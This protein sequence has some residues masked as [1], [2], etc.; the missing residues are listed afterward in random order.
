VDINNVFWITVQVDG[1][2]N[3]GEVNLPGIEQFVVV[4]QA[5]STNIQLLNGQQSL[6]VQ[7]Q[8]Q[9]QPSTTGTFVIGPAS[10]LVW[11]GVIESNTVTIEV[12][13]EKLFLQPQAPSSVV[14]VQEQEMPTWGWSQDELIDESDKPWFSRWWLL[15]LLIWGA[16]WSYYRGRKTELASWTVQKVTHK[17]ELPS[18]PDGDLPDDDYRMQMDLWWRAQLM[19]L[20]DQELSSASYQEVR[21]SF[22]LLDHTLQ[23]YFSEAF[24]LLEQARYANWSVDKAEFSELTHRF[25]SAQQ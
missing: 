24:I 2:D 14:A 9:V 22:T 17:R 18:L 5:N 15:P 4:G 8:L 12:T 20:T 13:G 10:I 21:R 16:V 11:T 19:I 7:L 6:Q 25:I 1:V 3:P 23:A